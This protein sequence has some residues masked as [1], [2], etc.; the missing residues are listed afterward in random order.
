MN[1]VHLFAADMAAL[2]PPVPPPQSPTEILALTANAGTLIS[3]LS[4]AFWWF[5]ASRISGARKPSAGEGEAMTQRNEE[6]VHGFRAATIAALFQAVTTI[7][8]MYAA[9]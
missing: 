3:T 8:S 7:V 4:A 2:L 6:I 1:S 9:H 5:R